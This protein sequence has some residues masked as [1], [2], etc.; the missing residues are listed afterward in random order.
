[1]KAYNK[2]K[3][4]LSVDAQFLGGLLKEKNKYKFSLKKLMVPGTVLKAVPKA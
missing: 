2:N 3:S 4:H 1:L